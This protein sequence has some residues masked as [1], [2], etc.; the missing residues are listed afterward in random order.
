MNV[1][2]RI[3]PLPER[4]TDHLT[5]M[6]GNTPQNELDIYPSIIKHAERDGQHAWEFSVDYLSLN[7][8]EERVH[9]TATLVDDNTI[10]LLERCTDKILDNGEYEMTVFEFCN[11]YLSELRECAVYF[12]GRKEMI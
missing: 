4:I 9:A 12:R 10:Q 11:D 2:A 7:D 5:N 8:S 6:F 1:T 3:T